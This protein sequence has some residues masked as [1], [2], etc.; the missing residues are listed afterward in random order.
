MED[1]GTGYHCLYPERNH[2]TTTK[3]KLLE[4]IHM[5]LCL[6][7]NVQNGDFDGSVENAF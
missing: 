4:L 7:P 1:E 6:G 5:E 2:Y 3:E